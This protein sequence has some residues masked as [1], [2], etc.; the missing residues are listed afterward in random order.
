M[1]PCLATPPSATQA[2]RAG[3]SSRPPHAWLRCLCHSRRMWQPCTCACTQLHVTPPAHPPALPMPM[4][5]PP[6]P[7]AA[8]YDA[9]GAGLTSE[10]AV[11]LLYALL[12]GCP[13]FHEY[14]LVR[15]GLTGWLALAWC[16]L[17]S[18][19]SVLRAG[20]SATLLGGSANCARMPPS[21]PC[22]L[23]ASASLPL[24]PV[25][26]PCACPHPPPPVPACAGAVRP[27]H[28]AAAAAGA[29][30]LGARAN[31]QPGAL[32]AAFALACVLGP[33]HGLARLRQLCTLPAPAHHPPWRLMQAEAPTSRLAGSALL[34]SIST[35]RPVTAGCNQNPIG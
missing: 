18:L 17:L 4:P 22:A 19:R 1:R 24:I 12:H 28:A 33:Y 14:C 3:C 26:I 7:P 6:P 11:L 5:L 10:R 29:A 34:L 16:T 20:G 31:L 30:V 27:G 15:R 8:L 35:F 25:P 21:I 32:L 9:L 23:P 13:R 2:R